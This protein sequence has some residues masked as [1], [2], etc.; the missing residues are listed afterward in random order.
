[1]RLGLFLMIVLAVVCI[2]IVFLNK[3][4]L[5]VKFWVLYLLEWV[6]E[7][8]I[9]LF[10][11]MFEGLIRNCGDFGLERLFLVIFRLLLKVC[12]LLVLYCSLGGKLMVIMG[13]LVLLDVKCR[14]IW[15]FLFWL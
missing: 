9:V 15:R 12:R 11:E 2:I 3:F 6:M 14:C 1:M 13:V 8:F 7:K 4:F 5:M 10:V